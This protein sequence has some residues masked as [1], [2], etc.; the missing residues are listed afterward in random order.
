M[1]YTSRVGPH[2]LPDGSRHVGLVDV[3]CDPSVRHDMPVLD[4]EETVV[5]VALEAGAHAGEVELEIEAC[6]LLREVFLELFD[7][8]AKQ[9]RPRLGWVGVT[10]A[11]QRAELDT[12]DPC[13]GRPDGNGPDACIGQVGRVDFDRGQWASGPTFFLSASCS[14]S[15]PSSA[16]LMRTGN[17][18]T[19]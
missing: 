11:W 18:L 5:D 2:R 1:E 19:P 7:R 13:V 9:E 6:P 15:K 3:L 14:A 4:L 12:P 8:R 17:L 16:H 10:L